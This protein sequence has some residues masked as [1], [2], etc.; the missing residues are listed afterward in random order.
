MPTRN[1]NGTSLNYEEAGPGQGA[2]AIVLLHGFP[3]DS[4]VWTSQRDELSKSHRVITPD[5]RGFGKSASADPFTMDSNAD[6][7]HALLADLGALPVVLGGLSMGGYAALAYA[8]KCPTD[9]RGLLLIDTRAEADAPEGREGR[10]KMIEMAQQKGGKAVADAMMPK[11]LGPDTPAKRPDV[12][13]ELRT[14]MESQPPRTVENA[15]VAMRDRPDFRKDLPSIAVPTLILVGE[16][17]AITPLAMAQTLNKSIRNSQ[18]VV[19]KHA[20]HMTPMEQPEQVN[21]AIRDFVSKL[22]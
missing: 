13:R 1:V 22:A 6:D 20:G 15:L 21:R 19:I 14:I 11:M 8:K 4:R 18:L 10:Q 12:A 2:M 9:L 5:L 7:D 16:S 17:D 3:L